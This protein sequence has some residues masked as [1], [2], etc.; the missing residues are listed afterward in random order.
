MLNL[1][2]VF[3]VLLLVVFSP[4][5]R[6]SGRTARHTVQP[7]IRIAVLGFTRSKASV[8]SIALEL[9]LT[10]A[11]SRDPRVTLIDQSIV[12][13]ATAGFRYDGS[14]N[15]SK[16]EARNLGAA[17]GADFFILGKAEA[18]TRSDHANESHEQAYAGV[19]IADGRTGALAAFDFISDNAP[20]RE[21]AKQSLINALAARASGYVDRL[22]QLNDR[23]AM[24][25]SSDS[26]GSAADHIE[27]IPAEDSPRSLGF[28]PPEFLNRVKPEYS[29]EADL[30]DITAT[31]EA[32]AVFGSNGEIGVIEI[33]RWA[34]FGLDE[35]AVRAIRQLKFKPATRDG[36][37]IN[38]RA[39][40]RYNF[41]RLAEPAGEL[42]ITPKPPQPE[43]D[44]RQIFK[45]TFKPKR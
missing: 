12:R 27:V 15:L 43:R 41:R 16:E 4:A 1:S 28:K 17:I 23:K 38:V 19:M 34:G 35:S 20:T 13:P 6:I 8:D 37:P 3:S 30:A 39:L 45:P 9:M 18:F 29:P 11:L 21:A 32:M 25:R 31:V 14:I 33:T 22:I 24:R 40:I 42:Q 44:L 26:A 2:V 10:E 5:G 7:S 36:N